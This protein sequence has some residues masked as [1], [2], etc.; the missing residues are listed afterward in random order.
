[1]EDGSE[2]LEPGKGEKGKKV[3]ISQYTSDSHEAPRS[4]LISN[5]G[6]II[7]T[8]NKKEA[9]HAH[10]DDAPSNERAPKKPPS[11]TEIGSSKN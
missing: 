8:G 11:S 1:M 3:G 5:C 4:P 7:L 9:A 10:P 2:E 6:N